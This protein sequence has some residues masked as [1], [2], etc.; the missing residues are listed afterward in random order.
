MIISFM[1][2]AQSYRTSRE[3]RSCPY[4]DRETIRSIKEGI[5]ITDDALP[6]LYE[7]CCV[8]LNHSNNH[9]CTRAFIIYVFLTRN[10]GYRMMRDVL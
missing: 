10:T 6:T 8:E 9:A 2:L 3:A 4:R 7:T 5:R 1:N